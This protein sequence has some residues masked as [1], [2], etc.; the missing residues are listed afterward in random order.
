ML[1]CSKLPIYP[2]LASVLSCF[3]TIPPY[4]INA[5]K[6]VDIDIRNSIFR[7]SE[8]EQIKKNTANCDNVGWEILQEVRRITVKYGKP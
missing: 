4:S 8:S 3:Q 2:L 7:Y 5:H 6:N 1:N